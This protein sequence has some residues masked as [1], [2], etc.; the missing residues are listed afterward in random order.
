[1]NMLDS[2]EEFVLEY[3][4]IRN[5]I[6]VLVGLFLLVFFFKTAWNHWHPGTG[7]KYK[8]VRR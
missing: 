7:K 6:I 5:G 8:K 4:L 2:L 1:M 3:H